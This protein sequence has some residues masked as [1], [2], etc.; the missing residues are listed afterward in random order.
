MRA[1]LSIHG[2]ARSQ[3]PAR[4]LRD[5]RSSARD[6]EACLVVMEPHRRPR[7]P[8]RQRAHPNPAARDTKDVMSRLA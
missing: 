6:A 5:E 7:T 8:G 3:N 2:V 1:S 4:A